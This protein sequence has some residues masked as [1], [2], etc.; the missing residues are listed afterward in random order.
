MCRSR[1]V[2]V[3]AVV[4]CLSVTFSLSTA[5]TRRTK[6]K[7]KHKEVEI[8][9]LNLLH[10]FDCDPAFDPEL[11]DQDQGDQCRL[12]DRVDL[13]FKHLAAIGCPDIVTLQ[14]IV[15]REF[16]PRGAG[17]IVGPLDSTKE[18]IEAQL[19][20]L[21]TVCGFQY[22]LLYLPVPGT[23]FEGT[24]EE[25][26]LS[27][28]PIVEAESRLLHSA[29]FPPEI[30]DLQFFARHVLF[31]RIDH[32]V[33]PI[34]VFTTHLSSGS[35]FAANNCN[36]LADLG[37]GFMIFVPCPEECDPTKSVRV[38]QALQLALFVEERHDVSTPAYVSG[39]MNAMPGSTEYE[40][41][42]SRGWVDTHLAA[43]NPECDP[44]TGRGCTSGRDEVGG[45]LEAPELNVDERIDYVFLV[46]ADKAR[47]CK[48][49][50]AHKRRSGL[51]AAEP[52]PFVDVC[53]PAPFPICWASD[54]TGNFGNVRC[55]KRLHKIKKMIMKPYWRG[56]GVE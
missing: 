8:A 2:M 26:I 48:L 45:D 17:E 46:P 38:C 41:F 27:R 51:F 21:V 55:A 54:H 15:D 22:E 56:W 44:T 23:F 6:H 40:T 32:P 18:L 7:N 4:I 47:H 14:E 43:G 33:G 37:G 31:A 1:L 53:G 19:G 50:R 49:V 13:L 5:S 16:V 25:L 9:N 10:G 36:S 30:E 24:D 11:P 29:L 3:V 34:D 52:N 12:A 28:Y 42:V 39:D 35:D 20:P